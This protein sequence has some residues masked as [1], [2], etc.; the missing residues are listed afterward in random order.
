MNTSRQM[1]LVEPRHSLGHLR[2]KRSRH[3]IR[4]LFLPLTRVCKSRTTLRT[5]R[6][7]RLP[8]PPFQLSPLRSLRRLAST[9]PQ[10][11]VEN[12][13]MPLIA[14]LCRRPGPMTSNHQCSRVHLCIRARPNIHF[15]ILPVLRLETVLVVPP[16]FV[17]HLPVQPLCLARHLLH[18]VP[19]HFV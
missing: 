11:E 6:T 9:F 3:R 16:H 7:I 14:T 12:L 15:L 1:L 17:R 4:T 10:T 13:W 5:Q 19:P 8:S 18:L 2:R